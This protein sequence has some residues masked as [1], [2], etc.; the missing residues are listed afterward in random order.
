M[1]QSGPALR[2]R[3]DE[4]VNEP[5]VSGHLLKVL[6]KSSRADVISLQNV[7]SSRKAYTK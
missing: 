2:P 6:Q 7:S 4:I 1:G 3:V 5:V